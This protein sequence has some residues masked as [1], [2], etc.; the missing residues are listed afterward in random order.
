MNLADLLEEASSHWPDRPLLLGEPDV[1]YRDFLAGVNGLASLL[2]NNG[3][4]RGAQIGAIL[5]NGP[6]LLYLWMALARLGAALVPLN[7]A[8]PF[9]QVEPLLRQVGI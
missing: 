3:V 1:S 9:P 4:R 7:P 8:L 2:A 6:E 5:P